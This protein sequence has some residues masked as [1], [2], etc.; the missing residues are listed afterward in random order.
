[1]CERV[2]RNEDDA[3]NSENS[4]A[5]FCVAGSSDTDRVSVR[6]APAEGVPEA[7]VSISDGESYD[8][9]AVLRTGADRA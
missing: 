4:N 6:T 5:C 7:P 2:R 9:G 1:M 3:Y 8:L